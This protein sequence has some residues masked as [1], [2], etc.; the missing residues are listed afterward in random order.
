MLNNS[1]KILVK[2]STKRFKDLNSDNNY[3]IIL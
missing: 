2:M 3:N 1:S